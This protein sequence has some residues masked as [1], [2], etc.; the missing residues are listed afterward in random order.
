MTQPSI[1]KYGSALESGDI[2][3]GEA[4]GLSMVYE[5]QPSSSLPGLLAVET[6]HGFLYLDPETE[7]EIVDEESSAETL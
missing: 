1:L 5:V 7:F 3:I 4:G 6:E 2:L